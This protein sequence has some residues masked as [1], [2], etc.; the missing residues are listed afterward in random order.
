MK[1]SFI[2][3]A[4][5]VVGAVS[6]EAADVSF[7]NDVGN[8]SYFN[9]TNW[10]DDAT[11]PAGSSFSNST[12][13]ISNFSISITS[14]VDLTGNGAVLQLLNGTAFTVLSNAQLGVGSGSAGGTV[15]V[16]SNAVLRGQSPAAGSTA[17]RILLNVSGGFGGTTPA[18]TLE[19]KPGSVLSNFLFQ[20]AASGTASIGDTF[21]IIGDGATIRGISFGNSV[22]LSPSVYLTNTAISTVTGGTFDLKLRRGQTFSWVGTS[23]AA[24]T[25]VIGNVVVD[26]DATQG[27]SGG[28][29][30]VS[31][32][33]TNAFSQMSRLSVATATAASGATSSVQVIN[34]ARFTAFNFLKAG[35]DNTQDLNDNNGSTVSVSVGSNTRRSPR[36]PR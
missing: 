25:F 35:A 13:T 2:I 5:A 3:Y 9:P 34:G 36:R 28:R 19:L 27:T 21:R 12:A 7:D 23:P 24:P 4:I 22:A 8:L 16:G 15:I 6:S 17:G 10:S 33:S 32:G 31:G 20:T 26:D 11:V 18:S 29:I 14:S 30:I 1:K